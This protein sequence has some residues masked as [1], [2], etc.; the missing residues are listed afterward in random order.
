MLPH[1]TLWTDN[2]QLLVLQTMGQFVVAE[3]CMSSGIGEDALTQ[4]ECSFVS[5]RSPRS[6]YDEASQNSRA[7]VP[8]ELFSLSISWWCS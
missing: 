2:C 8:G 1:Q 7:L 5:A 6:Y 3:E 4:Y